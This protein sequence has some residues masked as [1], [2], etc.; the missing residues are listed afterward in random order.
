MKQKKKLKELTI[1]DNFMFG[2]VMAEEDN[3]RRLLELI[4]G[5]SIKHVKVSRE[6]SI[7][8]HP[9][10]KGIR[11]DV[12]AEDE[13]NTH[14]NVEMQVAKKQE[15]G[16]RSRYYHGQID[17][18]LL[19]AG[20]D[21][22]ELPDTYVIFICDF[23]PFK[24]GRYQYTFK[25][26]C[27]EEKGME[28]ADGGVSI[29][30]STCGKDR[31]QVPEALIRF[32]GFV[33]ADLKESTKDFEDSYIRQLQETIMRIKGSREMEERFMIFEE[34]L[35]DE[36]AEGKAE[37]IAEGRAMGISE[38]KAEDIL[39]LLSELGMVSDEL[40]EKIMNE[41]DI[42]TLRRYLRCAAKAESIEQFSEEIQ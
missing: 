12:Y 28:L 33:G 37:G 25:N 8:Y 31:E 5:I 14:Y 30:L 11:L 20:R 36:R 10:Y 21:Y 40:T 16:K 13:N 15:L 42:P 18:E 3:C 27:I 24:R 9:E 29:F 35:R 19:L 7:V 39:E 17:M 2:A 34:M 26:L 22:T 23:D 38:G 41:K 4:L 1:K 32:L 6:K